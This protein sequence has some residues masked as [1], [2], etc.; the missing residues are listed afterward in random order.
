MLILSA[1]DV[2]AALPMA[3]A[4]AAMKEA[5]AAY[6]SGQATVPPRIHL[7]LKAP[8]G[9]SLVMPSHVA[10]PGR[11]SL[12]VKVV[13]LF[14]GNRARGLA[15]IQSAVVA[16]DP[17]TGRPEALLEGATLTAIRTGA[18]SGAATDL[19]APP[20]AATVAI[21]GAGVQART[22]LEAVCAVRPI[23]TA[24]IVS[25]RPES[26]EQLIAEMAGRGPIPRDLRRAGDAA[27][28]LRDA[29]IVC[30]ATA[31][32]GGPLFADA[33][34]KPGAHLNAIG[35]FQ[36]GVVEIPAATVGRSWVAVDSRGAAR[37]E[38][39]DLIQAVAAG[40]F[41]WSRIRAELGE[42]VNGTVAPPDRS[43]PVTTLFKSV[44]LAVQD[45]AAARVALANAR[46]KALGVRAPW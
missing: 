21:L 39:G 42:V 27:A 14:P 17:A 6:S 37:E 22:Q 38:A 25:R 3:D 15:L 35:S 46:L 4:I 30:A 23:E 40:T 32:A 43:A 5:F 9:V 19:L 28:A 10:V 2:R 1:E 13:S 45:S 7:D 26:A 16:L 34:L 24:W 29:D 33:A 41:S 11:E 12:A 31:G 20:G 44:G 36:P 8:E 18:A